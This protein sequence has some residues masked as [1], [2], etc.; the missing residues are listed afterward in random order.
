[1]L[2]VCDVRHYQYNKNRFLV[3]LWGEV[4][5]TNLQN[6]PYNFHSPK[7]CAQNLNTLSIDKICNQNGIVMEIE[8]PA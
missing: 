7:V 6:Q 2:F 4:T 1:M 8:I 5:N 3:D